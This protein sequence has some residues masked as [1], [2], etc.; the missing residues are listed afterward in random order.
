MDM[1]SWGVRRIERSGDAPGV[2]R[3]RAGAGADVAGK[4]ATDDR[5]NAAAVADADA[6]GRSERASGDD[7]LGARAL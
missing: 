4:H 5:G 3:L 1:D 7:A 2:R 6:A